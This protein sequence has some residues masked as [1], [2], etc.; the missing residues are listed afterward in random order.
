MFS[1]AGRAEIVRGPIPIH[2]W[3][4]MKIDD[5]LDFKDFYISSVQVFTSW[6]GFF[7]VD[8]V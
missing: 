6:V 7:I 1:Q 4:F 5:T 8:R 2:T 3:G